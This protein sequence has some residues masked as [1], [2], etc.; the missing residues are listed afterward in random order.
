[1]IACFESVLSRMRSCICTGR[2]RALLVG[3]VLFAAGALLMGLA[4]GINSLITG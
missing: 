4:T 1:M 2:K 3:D